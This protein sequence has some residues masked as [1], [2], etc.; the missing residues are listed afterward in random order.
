MIEQRFLAIDACFVSL[1]INLETNDIPDAFAEI[2]VKIM[3]AILTILGI[4]T[5]YA[6]KNK[7]G[8]CIGP[9]V[10]QC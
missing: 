5:K 10:A 8:R 2:T 3:V 6:R 9:F 1:R 4:A 7:V